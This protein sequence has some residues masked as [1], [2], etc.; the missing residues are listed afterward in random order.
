LARVACGRRMEQLPSGASR[1]AVRAAFEQARDEINVAVGEMERWWSV[2][3]S[4]EI[5]KAT[6]EP[7]QPD[8]AD[9]W[10]ILAAARAAR[11]QYLLSEDARSFSHG[12]CYSSARPS[13]ELC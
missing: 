6:E 5:R 3:R 8:D 1:E 7:E 2:P 13:H 12:R 11:A 4:V 10:P 9:D